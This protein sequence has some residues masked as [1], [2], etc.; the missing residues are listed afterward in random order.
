MSESEEGSNEE[1]EGKKDKEE[2][3]IANGLFGYEDHSSM[4]RVILTT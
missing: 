4:V 1:E 3:Y 2:K